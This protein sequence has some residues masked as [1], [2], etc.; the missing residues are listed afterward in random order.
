MTI[1]Q[2]I[3]LAASIG[4]CL[5]ALAAFFA[6]HLAS[7]HSKAS[8]KPELVIA[9]TRFKSIASGGIPCE[10]LSEP[11][12]EDEN[13][14][15]MMF[16]VP[17]RNVGLGAAKEVDINWSFPIEELVSTVN[18]LAQ[19]SLIPAYFD[20]N[21]GVLSLKAESGSGH[22]S[23]WKNQQNQTVDFVLPAPVD[24]VPYKLVLPLAYTQLVSALVYFSAKSDSF[25]SFP[26]IPSLHASL[27]YFDIGGAKH[28]NNFAIESNINMIMNKGEEFQGY[29]ESKN[30]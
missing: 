1:D 28:K 7:K 10:W 6:V 15:Q 23:I 30:A 11:E 9:R 13:T 12:N 5:S 25:E 21:N 22:T 14:P 16:S 27:S 29:V 18:E 24:Q 17:L 4:A 20:Y 2:G 3:S 26:E 8:Y 19:K